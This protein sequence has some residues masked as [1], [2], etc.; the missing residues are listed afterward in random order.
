MEYRWQRCLIMRG[1]SN[2]DL[3]VSVK[4]TYFLDGREMQPQGSC[5]LERSSSN[6]IQYTNSKKKKV[7]K[8][9]GKNETIYSPFL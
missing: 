4:F 3:P 6:R 1:Q 9:D 5:R 7:Q 2:K 8:V